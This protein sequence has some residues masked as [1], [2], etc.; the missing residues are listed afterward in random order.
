MK[1]VEPTFLKIQKKNNKRKYICTRKYKKMQS[2]YKQHRPVSFKKTEYVQRLNLSEV[3]TQ[4]ST[5]KEWY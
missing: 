4:Y 3:N 5:R 2:L 1:T